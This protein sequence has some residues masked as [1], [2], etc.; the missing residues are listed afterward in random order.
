MPLHTLLI[1]PTYHQTIHVYIHRY[2]YILHHVGRPWDNK[3]HLL[4]L[5]YNT[6]V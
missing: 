5:S 3:T 6:S 4:S 2:I 1:T